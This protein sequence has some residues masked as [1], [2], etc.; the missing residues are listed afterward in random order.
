MKSEQLSV[1]PVTWNSYPVFV[2][3]PLL[4]FHWQ[5]ILGMSVV[6]E[7]RPGCAWQLALICELFS[8]TVHQH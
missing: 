1:H 7:Y 6:P 2:Y 3:N 4:Y 5:D 8:V